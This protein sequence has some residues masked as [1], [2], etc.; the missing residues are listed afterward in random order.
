MKP[1]NEEKDKEEEKKKQLFA[2]AR[3]VCEEEAYNRFTNA[4][5]SLYKTKPEIIEKALQYCIE[6]Y[7]RTR[8]KIDEEQLKK[9]LQS[10]TSM[11]KKETRII[12]KRK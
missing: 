7:R 4:F 9:V 3:M 8:K 12:F 2:L 11:E 6:Y 1:N 10:L 5:Y